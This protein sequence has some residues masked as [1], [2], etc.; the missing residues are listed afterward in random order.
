MGRDTINHPLSSQIN[1]VLYYDDG[2]VLCQR[3]DYLCVFCVEAGIRL[4]RAAQ[5]SA[6]DAAHT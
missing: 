5:Q 6:A 3:L 4:R 2:L 1:N